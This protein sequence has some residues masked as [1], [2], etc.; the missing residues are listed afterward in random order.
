MAPRPVCTAQKT[1]GPLSN[2]GLILATANVSLA[3]RVGD[4]TVNQF[5]VI[6]LQVE[7]IDPHEVVV[8]ATAPDQAASLA[9]G[10]DL[11]RSG[12]KQ[13]LRARV[14][15]K[16][17]GQPLTMVRLYAKSRDSSA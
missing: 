6:D 11:V 13:A 17:A 7:T 12:S 14:Y 8:Q 15:F 5:R 9:L 10:V 4:V 3:G 2:Q 1:D 16:N